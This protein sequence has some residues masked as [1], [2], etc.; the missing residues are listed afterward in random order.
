MIL[1]FSLI[2]SLL[3]KSSLFFI[4]RILFFKAILFMNYISIDS[5]ILEWTFF[6]FKLVS[7]SKFFV[8]KKHYPFKS[9]VYKSKM[10]QGIA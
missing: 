6:I 5:L 1:L 9:E 8:F 2:K 3:S 10:S 4:F 7:P